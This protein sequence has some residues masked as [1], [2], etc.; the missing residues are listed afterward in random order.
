MCIYQVVFGKIRIEIDFYIMN[1][2]LSELT[3]ILLNLPKEGHRVSFT[4]IH[5]RHKHCVKI[6]IVFRSKKIF[7]ITSTLELVLVTE[8][9]LNILQRNIF[10]IKSKWWTV[11]YRK[12]LLSPS[13]SAINIRVWTR[14]EE[15]CNRILPENVWYSILIHL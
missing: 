5:N 3:L 14:N 8:T 9:T 10:S 6:Y 15:N 12:S 4:P 13:Y 7:Y 2:L 1:K 11:R